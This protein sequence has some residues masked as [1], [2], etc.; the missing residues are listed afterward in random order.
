MI[1]NLSIRMKTTLIAGCLLFGMIALGLRS[2]QR[3]AAGRR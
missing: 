3:C 1:A 2:H